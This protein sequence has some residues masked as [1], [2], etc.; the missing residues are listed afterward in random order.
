MKTIYK[1]L[2]ALAVS[3]FLL[4]TAGGQS[5]KNL[6]DSTTYA[7]EIN[8]VLCGYADSE[9]TTTQKNGKEFLLVEN[10]ILAKLSALGGG[11]DMTIENKFLLNPETYNPVSIEHV[12]AT[13]AEVYT[14][15]QFENGNAFFTNTRGGDLRKIELDKDVIVENSVFYPHLMKDFIR[16][17]ENEKSYRVYDDMKGAIVTKSYKLLGKETLELIGKKFNS[18]VVEELN[19]E[20]GIITKYGWIMTQASL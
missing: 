3:V 7:V 10:H 19:H 16:G 5:L 6:P 14:F 15:T 18:T 9:Y 1:L 12:A 17:T 4:T 2:Y 11:I 20:L 13:T 8:G